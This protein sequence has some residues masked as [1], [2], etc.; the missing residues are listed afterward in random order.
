MATHKNLEKF[1]LF[2]DWEISIACQDGSKAALDLTGGAVRFRLSDLA[3][4]VLLLDLTS[5][6]GVAIIDA[7]AGKAVVEIDKAR[8]QTATIQAGPYRYEIEAVLADGTP[9]IQA[10]G[11]LTVQ[12][13]LFAAFP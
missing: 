4:T 9:S 3:R 5:P 10:E 12:P 1:K 2:E 13:S 6:D 7:P 11:Q 8:Q